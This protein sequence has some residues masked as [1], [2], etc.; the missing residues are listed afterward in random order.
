[1]SQTIYSKNESAAKNG[2]FGNDSEC[3]EGTTVVLKKE[4]WGRSEKK[5]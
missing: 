5:V 4:I 2:N 1:M 3:G